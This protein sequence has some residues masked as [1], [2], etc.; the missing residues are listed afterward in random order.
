MTRRSWRDSI[1]AAAISSNNQE[2]DITGRGQS[3]ASA[4]SNWA[5][6]RRY[7]V[8]LWLRDDYLRESAAFEADLPDAPRHYA[9]APV[10]P[11]YLIGR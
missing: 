4:S 3:R 2:R 10:T 8:A 7:M 9:R 5:G 11:V 6:R 1:H